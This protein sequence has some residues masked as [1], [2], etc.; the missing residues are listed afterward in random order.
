MSRS[1]P[2][3]P[4]LSR[5]GSF[6]RVSRLSKPN[7]FDMDLSGFSILAKRFLWQGSSG[8]Q[9]FPPLLSHQH[10]WGH[11]GALYKNTKYDKNTKVR[12]S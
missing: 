12:K 3:V 6:H 2:C 5:P 10:G 7:S 4:V 9:C 8:Q 1:Q 11:T